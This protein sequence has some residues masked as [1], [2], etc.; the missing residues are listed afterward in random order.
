MMIP[1]LLRSRRFME[2][3]RKYDKFR[4][5]KIVSPFEKAQKDKKKRNDLYEFMNDWGIED[6][7]VDL[8]DWDD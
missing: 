5:S 1:F 4:V 7:D 8:I 2:K 3:V 6:E